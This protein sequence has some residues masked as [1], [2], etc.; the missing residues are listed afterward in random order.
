MCIRYI[1]NESFAMSVMTAGAFFCLMLEN[2]RNAPKVA[3]STFGVQNSHAHSS[4]GVA[5]GFSGSP[6]Q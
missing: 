1:P 4:S 2:M 5:I 6:F 3:S